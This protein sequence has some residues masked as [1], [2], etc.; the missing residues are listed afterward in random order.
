[1]QHKRFLS[2]CRT[3]DIK[4]IKS[5]K[6]KRRLCTVRGKTFQSNTM[7]PP[8]QNWISVCL[9][10][11]TRPKHY[12]RDVITEVAEPNKLFLN[13]VFFWIRKKPQTLAETL[14]VWLMFFIFF[15]SVLHPSDRTAQYQHHYVSW[16]LADCLQPG[17]LSQLVKSKLIYSVQ[18]ER[19]E[20]RRF[21]WVAG[22]S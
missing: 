16:T 3:D 14:W 9:T 5:K 7:T 6:F 15:L 10:Q 18:W 21:T 8:Q 20:K 22:S 12:K 19:G 2:T 17:M 13:G 1:M 11:S 4:S